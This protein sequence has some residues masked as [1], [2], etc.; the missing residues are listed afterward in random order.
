MTTIVSP[1]QLSGLKQ[2]AFVMGCLARNDSEDQIV[3]M[4]DGDEQLFKMW[5]LFV[6]YNE[7]VEES[8]QG[9][10]MTAKGSMWSKRV[11]ST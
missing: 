10:S 7:W 2:A 8:I 1:A 9:W 4:L 6:K 3:R 5:K 11:E